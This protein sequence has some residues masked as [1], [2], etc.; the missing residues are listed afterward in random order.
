[1]LVGAGT[2]LNVDQVATVADAGGQLIV[3]PNQSAAVIRASKA[4]GLISLS[5]VQTASECFAA[6]DAG[7]DG[8]KLFPAQSIPPIAVK[9]LRAVL[10]KSTRLPAVGG[11]TP[12]NMQEYRAAGC[13]GFGIGDSLY[14]P[15]VRVSEVAAMAQEFGERAV[16]TR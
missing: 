10:P 12:A 3:S 8:L 5:G 1:M 11:I 13:N 9:A 15:G 2:V 14:R 6:L 16:E 7:A 4:R